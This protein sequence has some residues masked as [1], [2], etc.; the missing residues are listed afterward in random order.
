MSMTDSPKAGGAE[1]RPRAELLAM[2]DTLIADEIVSDSGPEVLRW[3]SLSSEAAERIRV[4]APTPTP[5]ATGGEESALAK[6]TDL[7]FSLT[8]MET[9]QARKTAR[10]LQR[11]FTAPPPPA[12]GERGEAA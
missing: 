1:L 11:I 7:I 4:D 12:A 3:L 5:M 9:E 6:A 8:D 2:L 10:L